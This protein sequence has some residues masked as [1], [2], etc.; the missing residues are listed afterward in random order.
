M[1]VGLRSFNRLGLD[2]LPAEATLHTNDLGFGAADAGT[3][4]ERD[5]EDVGRIDLQLVLYLQ[6][7]GARRRLPVQAGRNAARRYQKELELAAGSNRLDKEDLV[8]GAMRFVRNSRRLAGA[9]EQM[10]ET[11][12]LRPG[13]PRRCG[14]CGPRGSGD[15]GLGIHEHAPRVFDRGDG[16]APA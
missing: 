4:V 1:I 16:S 3:G 5:V 12:N 6:E 2:R 13:K 10:R 7:R 15:A 14:G 9:D 11:R 8:Q